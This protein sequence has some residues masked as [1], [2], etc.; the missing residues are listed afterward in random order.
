MI[1]DQKK[2]GSCEIVF[3]EEEI[4]IITQ[5]KKLYL[6]QEFLRHFSNT[7]VNITIEFNKRFDEKTKKLTTF[8]N[9]KIISNKPKK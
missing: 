2:D 6:T 4:K 3:S 1:F 7:L 5:H 9:T 8:N